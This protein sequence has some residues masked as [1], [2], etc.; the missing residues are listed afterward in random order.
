M[1]KECEFWIT[2]GTKKRRCSVQHPLGTVHVS[3]PNLAV[4]RSLTWSFHSSQAPSELRTLIR[5]HEMQV[6]LC[7]LLA[8][9]GSQLQYAQR[10]SETQNL[11]PESSMG[12]VSNRAGGGPWATNSQ[13]LLQLSRYR[14]WAH[15]PEDISLL[16]TIFLSPKKRCSLCLACLPLQQL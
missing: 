6:S 16:A 14:P 13:A 9:N 11:G 8:L 3:W 15:L 2:P 12:L 10:L 5:A 4:P 7:W 1:S